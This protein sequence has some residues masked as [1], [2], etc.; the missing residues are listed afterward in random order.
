MT[1][2]V[3]L[4][5]A[6]YALSSAAGLMILK[7]A[8]GRMDGFS[9]TALLA[10]AADYRFWLGAFL[11]GTGFLIWLYMLRLRD[12]SQIFP[13]AA[14]SIF[15]AIFILTAIFTKEMVSAQRVLAA[16]VIV[17]GIALMK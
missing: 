10:L 11:Y 2:L 16:A 6:V 17:I 1:P 8:L 5:L 14:G 3:L 13:V 7:P 9:V 4:L 15:L 12:L